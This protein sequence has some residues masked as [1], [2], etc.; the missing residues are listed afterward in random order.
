MK[1]LILSDSHREMNYMRMAVKRERPDGIIHLG[2]H[3]ADGKSLALEFPAIPVCLVKGN[4]DYYE[5]NLPEER[6]VRWEEVT[7]FLT[8]GHRHGV[9]NGLL[10]LQYAAMEKGAQVALFGHTHIPFCGKAGEV[11]LLNPGA[12]GGRIPTYGI[13]EIEKDRINCSIIDLFGEEPA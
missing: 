12:C 4:C 10:R 7:V 6:T 8:H 13:V 1:L 2:D 3:A 11:H 9:K 5:M